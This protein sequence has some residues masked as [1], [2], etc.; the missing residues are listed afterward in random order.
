MPKNE[1]K[2]LARGT[3][4]RVSMFLKVRPIRCYSLG[5]NKSLFP[6]RLSVGGM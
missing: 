3:G 2:L 4:A 5:K 6:L 1:I